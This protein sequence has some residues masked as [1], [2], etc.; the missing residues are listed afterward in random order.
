MGTITHLHQRLRPPPNRIGAEEEVSAVVADLARR[1]SAAPS[2]RAYHTI[3]AQSGLLAISIPADFGGLDVSNVVLGEAIAV[4]AATWPQS[5][6]ALVGHFEALEAIRNAGSEEQRRAIYAH[7]AAG[8]R[9]AVLISEFTE[10]GDGIRLSTEGIGYCLDGELVAKVILDSDWLLLTL[11]D[12]HG[13]PRFVLVSCED[14]GLSVVAA[15]ESRQ[16]FRFQRLHVAADTILIHGED[17]M[18][19]SRAVGHLM[20]GALTLGRLREDFFSA[21]RQSS[22]RRQH[23]SENDI[24][25]LQA[26]IGRLHVEAEQLAALVNRCGTEID[27]AQVTPGAHA[28]QRAAQSAEVVAIA[29]ARVRDHDASGSVDEVRLAELGAALAN[30]AESHPRPLESETPQ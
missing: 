9:L 6:T 3:V 11:A 18:L 23:A 20:E 19:M 4:L 2:D 25:Q 27:I 21:V 8:E 30:A 16:T 29:A 24:R 10:R 14:P 1:F 22:Q 13:N 17:A 15:A 12:E 28:I 5:A 26:E 7:V